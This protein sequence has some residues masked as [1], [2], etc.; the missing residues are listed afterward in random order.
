MFFSFSISD[1][2]TEIFEGFDDEMKNSK[3]KPIDHC[4]IVS[5][6]GPVIIGNSS[7]TN[8]KESKNNI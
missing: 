3:E 2:I 7:M 4:I 6:T 1:K 5:G 8:E